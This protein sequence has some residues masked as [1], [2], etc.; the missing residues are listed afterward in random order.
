MDFRHRIQV[1]KPL[2]SDNG[3]VKGPKTALNKQFSLV[4]QNRFNIFCHIVGRGLREAKVYAKY[5]KFCKFPPYI[6]ILSVPTRN[7]LSS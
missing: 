5:N 3:H 1:E 7:L 6:H 2:I 4:I